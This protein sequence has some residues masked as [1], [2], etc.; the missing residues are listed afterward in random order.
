[1]IL[2]V[3]VFGIS[4]LLLSNIIKRMNEMGEFEREGRGIGKEDLREVGM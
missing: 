4:H 3:F 2:G 1:M